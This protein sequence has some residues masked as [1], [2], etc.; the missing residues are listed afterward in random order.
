MVQSSG[1]GKSHMLTEVGKQIFML[2]ICLCKSGDPG[3]LPGDKPIVKF[4]SVLPRNNDLSI[5]VHAAIACFLAAAHEMMLE[6]LQKA[7]NEQGLI[8]Q[9]LLEY[10]CGLMEPIEAHDR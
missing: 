6:M 10:W 4:F 1:T 9:Q 2:Q 7:C 3:Y 8:G 5:T